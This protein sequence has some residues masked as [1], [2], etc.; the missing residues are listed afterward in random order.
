M[1][2]YTLNNSC[3]S[4]ANCSDVA[5][6]YIASGV[7]HILL[8]IIPVLV[9]GPIV[10]GIFISNK[11]LRD[12]VSVLYICTATLCVIGPLTYGLLMDLSLITTVQIFGSC[13]SK[14]PRT[15]WILFSTV[16]SHL[17]ASN[18]LLSSVQYVTT[19]WGKKKVSTRAAL[20]IFFT[21]LVVIFLANMNLIGLTEE[22]H[23]RGSLCRHPGQDVPYAYALITMFTFG[24]FTVPPFI[25][26]VVFSILTAVHIKKNT[27]N[28]GKSVK[29]VMKIVLI[30]TFTVIFLRFLPILVIFLGFDTTST[31]ISVIL[32]RSWYGIYS[33]EL[34]NPLFLFLAL[35]LHKTVR[36]TFLNKIKIKK[37]CPMFKCKKIANKISPSGLSDSIP[38]PPVVV[39]ISAARLEN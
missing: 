15:F 5:V 11:K 9:I 19:R 14:N 37:I 7:L 3:L 13:D 33:V 18:A 16:Q 23:V 8:V 6:F 27:I 30:W 34:S 36:V 35:F 24:V 38:L 28:D 39:Q 26:V 1:N 25:L 12:P 17:L 22:E 21:F 10:L 2:N 31:P 32:A 20:G 4:L 29:T